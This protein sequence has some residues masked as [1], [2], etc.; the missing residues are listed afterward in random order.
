MSAP[1]KAIVLFDLCAEDDDAIGLGEVITFG[2]A[3][4]LG[5]ALV[6]GEDL[7]ALSRASLNP[8]KRTRLPVLVGVA[9]SS[10]WWA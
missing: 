7:R 5:E 8:S 9:L 1:V 3:I 10:D 2:E 4:T 6:L